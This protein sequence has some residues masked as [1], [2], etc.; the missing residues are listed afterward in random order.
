LLAGLV[1]PMGSTSAADTVTLRLHFQGHGLGMPTITA[2]SAQRGEYALTQL[3]L[4]EV[5][6]RRSW[7]VLGF[8][9]Q[10]SVLYRAPV[11]NQQWRR[12]EA[13]DPRTGRIAEVREMQVSQ[14]SFEVSFPYDARLARVALRTDA[15]S[16]HRRRAESKPLIELQRRDLDRVLQAGAGNAFAKTAATAMLIDNGAAADRLD[17]VFVGDGYTAAELGKWQADAQNVVAGLMSDRLFGAY[18]RRINIRRVDV[19][20]VES[21]VDEPDIGIFRDTALDSAFNCA[22]IARLLCASNTKV[23]SVV[24][25]VLEPDARD[26][27]IVVANSTRY[28]GSG[29]SLAAI[30]MH[31][32][33]TELALHEL[34]HT[35]FGLAD[36]YDYGTCDLNSEPAAGNASLIATRAVKWG[37]LIGTITSVPT[38]PGQYP[39]GTIGV[40]DGGQ[41]CKTGKYRPTE[42]SK[43]RSLGQPWHAVNEVLA[44]EVFARYARNSVRP[45]IRMVLPPNPPS[46]T[47]GAKG[48]QNPSGSSARQNDQRHRS[49]PAR[50]ALTSPRAPLRP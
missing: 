16:S 6:A 40:F 26:V 39:N 5:E 46:G 29:G 2:E 22:N 25:S 8:D 33:S 31:P 21:G 4:E 50:D 3:P 35:L 14:G 30:S 34:G 28:G 7:W 12:L 32:A 15:A 1:G 49:A 43:M 24:G 27:I 19:D 20:S 45:R 44:A 10:G 13:F 18:R 41:Y 9:A 42:D 37:W 48:A 36:E 23:L 47:L 17:L 38:V 11:R